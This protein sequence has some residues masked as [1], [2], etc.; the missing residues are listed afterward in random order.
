M[1]KIKKLRILVAE[2][3]SLIRESIVESL[4]TLG[5]E[6]AGEASNGVEAVQLARSKRPDLILMDIK[7][8]EMDGIEASKRIQEAQDVPILLLTAYETKH[9]VQ[10]ASDAGIVL[11]ML[12]PA[13]SAEI[14]RSVTIA[15]AR[16]EDLLKLK[17]LNQTLYDRTRE[18]ESALRELHA[19]RSI[20]PIC[21]NCKKIRNDEGYW[22]KV[23]SY[24]EKHSDVLFSHGLCPEC[25]QALYS[26]F[27]NENSKKMK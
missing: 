11:Y 4:Q 15:M 7:M 9:L 14:H 13:T 12:K 3:E 17:Q 16:H 25:E 20:L 24:F 19:L 2:D 6:V 27:L 8:P 5:Y 23:E 26:E 18:L 21:A 10:K 1:S 22:E